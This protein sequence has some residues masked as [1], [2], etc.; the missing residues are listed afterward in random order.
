MPT[1]T[2]EWT[3]FTP[4]LKI[5]DAQASIQFYCEV[6]G[7][8]LDWVHRFDEDFPA[9]ASVSRWPLIAH[10]SEHG[11][12]G[13]EQADLF[14]AVPDVDAVYAEFTA[15]GLKCDPPVSE[16]EIGLRSF[17]FEDPD[18][19]RLGFGTGISGADS[20]AEN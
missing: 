14:V 4:I 5:K 19:H 12:G 13:T 10:L 7:F 6:L 2:H 17:E 20:A 8:K 1:S 18:G 3:G 16:P 11:G 15:N 9:Y